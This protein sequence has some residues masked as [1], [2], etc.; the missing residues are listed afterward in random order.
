MSITKKFTSPKGELEWVTIDGEGKQNL[1]GK[2]QYVANVVINS[3]DPIVAEIEKFWE[4]NKP[5]GFK[6]D[7]KSNGLYPYKADL[8]SVDEDG[9]SIYEAVEDKLSMSFKTGTTYPDG[10]VKKIQIY[11]AKAR[12]V[13]L[14]VG[15]KIGNG[16]I[17]E[18]S[19]AMGIY[20]TMAPGGK[21]LIDAGVTLYLNGIKISKLME[22]DGAGDNF[23]P[24]GDDSE[25]WE[26][27][28]GWEGE[29]KEAASPA[30]KGKPRL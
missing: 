9:K 11:N 22:F 10:S 29:A 18:I 6:K 7:Y 8:G 3:S 1:S 23:E 24:D 17:G 13:E 26:G 15:V 2:L 20:E 16:S 4:A 14:P 25:G 27:D 12:K 5:K 28:E 21:T 30:P 19:G